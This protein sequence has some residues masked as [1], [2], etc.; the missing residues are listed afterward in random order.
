[1]TDSLAPVVQSVW[2]SKTARAVV[3]AVVVG[4]AWPWVRDVRAELAAATK[5]A[6]AAAD[7]AAAARRQMMAAERRLLA[8][9]RAR[10]RALWREV[11]REAASAEPKAALRAE[12]AATARLVFL[13]EADVQQLHERDKLDEAASKAL[14]TRAPK[15]DKPKR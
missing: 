11:G 2:K 9:E 13:D 5:Q 8:L 12:T 4:T 3:V 6:K 7:D 14:E 1:M 15:P 10:V